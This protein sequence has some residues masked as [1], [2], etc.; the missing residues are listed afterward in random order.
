MEKLKKPDSV[1]VVGGQQAGILTGPMYTLHKIISIIVLARQQEEKL[2]IPVV[3]VFWIAGEDHDILEVNH[4][5]VEKD[6]KL[7]KL[8][9]APNTLS[10]KMVSDEIISQDDFEKVLRDLVESLG[11]TQH[12]KELVKFL[13]S[14][15]KENNTYTE[16][17]STLINTWFADY[18]LLLIDAAD[19]SI[20]A[21][22]VPFFHRLIDKSSEITN[23]VLDQ[24][25]TLCA[26][27]YQKT[28]EIKEDATNLFLYE[29]QERELLSFDK[30][31]AAFAS[32][33]K[34]YTKEEL[35]QLVEIAPSKLSNNV[36][37]RPLMQEFLLPTLAFIAG[38]GEVSYWGELQT[39][40]HEVGFTMPPVVPRLH[41]SWVDR[42]MEQSL[43][44]LEMP[45][46]QAI[47]GEV[48]V[49]REKAFKA[50]QDQELLHQIDHMKEMFDKEFAAIEE[51]IQ[52]KHTSL[53]PIMKKNKEYH[54]RQLDFLI[55]KSVKQVER[56]HAELL[57]RYNRLER[58][59]HPFEG[60]Q[61]RI[62]NIT[63]FL[64]KYGF[65]IIPKLMD[66]PFEFKG[67][68]YLLLMSG[69]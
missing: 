2:G 65:S 54:Y 16:W 57:E 44:D 17:F 9:I 30:D 47:S 52:S 22:E 49:K 38:P 55:N 39:A 24:Q 4:L 45:I 26:S 48:S 36:V 12:T 21:L 62:W 31:K 51:R 5:F 6:K 58:M 18:G 29:D 59:L 66:Q 14:S 11:E 37:T 7:K 46:E 53:V 34:I 28:L 32:S 68:H 69:E 61:E 25:E 60:Y 35:R 23:A 15:F 10:K 8:Q 3:P 19:S 50:L 41:I 13:R 1:V 67:D 33:S 63:Y 43:R 27:G 56:D 20:R 40:F 64:N 42:R